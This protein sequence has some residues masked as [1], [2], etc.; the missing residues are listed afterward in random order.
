VIEYNGAVWNRCFSRPRAD[1][2]GVAVM[3]LAL[4]TEQLHAVAAAA[5]AAVLPQAV[6]I[7]EEP[8]T[9]RPSV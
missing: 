2:K 5:A 1:P 9:Q 4:Q 7:D 3:E 6:P 8:A